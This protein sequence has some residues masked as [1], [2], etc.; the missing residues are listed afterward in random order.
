MPVHFLLKPYVMIRQ[1][2]S[3][4]VILRRKSRL[5]DNIRH[6]DN[7]ILLIARCH[8]IPVNPLLLIYLKYCI[9][10]TFTRQIFFPDNITKALLFERICIQNLITTACLSGKRDK[11]VGLMQR[12]KLTDRI[13]TGPGDHDIGSVQK[14]TKLFLDVLILDIALHSFQ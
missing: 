5:I 11:N 14:V 6:H 10:K 8:G 2:M 7:S 4:F 3:V 13:G 9:Q 12:Q 1:S